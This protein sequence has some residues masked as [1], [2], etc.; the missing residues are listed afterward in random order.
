MSLFRQKP[1][2]NAAE[3]EKIA[4]VVQSAADKLNRRETKAMLDLNPIANAVKTVASPPPQAQ[5]AI[6]EETKAVPDTETTQAVP[7]P[8]AGK[9][10]NEPGLG[11]HLDVYDT[12]GQALPHPKTAAQKA[13][14]AQKEAIKEH[15]LG[16][17]TG[18]PQPT[19]DPPPPE[20]PFLKP[21]GHPLLGKAVD[22]T[23]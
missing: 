6:A 4:Q 8:A 23:V 22:A 20:L 1:K 13:E 11:E 14:Q 15:V 10:G 19:V 21:L 12:E 7:P 5:P 16:H 2:P 9:G 17:G 18:L 3:K